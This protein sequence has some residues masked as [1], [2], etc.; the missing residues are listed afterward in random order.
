MVIDKV[1]RL[2]LTDAGRIAAEAAIIAER[3]SGAGSSRE[4]KTA[5]ISPAEKAEADAE[6][7]A[8]RAK[9]LALLRKKPAASGGPGVTKD[10]LAAAQ[11]QVPCYTTFPLVHYAATVSSAASCAQSICSSITGITL[12]C[13]S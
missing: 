11:S 3:A 8:Y 13:H 9:A 6:A 12:L 7:A 1:L 2:P 4:G 5:T 10:V